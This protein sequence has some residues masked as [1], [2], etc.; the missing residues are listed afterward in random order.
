[1]NDPVAPVDPVVPIG[2]TATAGCAHLVR[3]PYML[4]IG[5]YILLM[6]IASTFLY[7][8]QLQIVDA[9]GGSTDEQTR[10]FATVNLASQGA[11]LVLQ[12]LVTASLLRVAGTGW[13]L[14][15]LPLISIVAFGVLLVSPVFLT[16]VVAQAAFN[17]GRFAFA[18]PARETLFTVLPREDRYKSKAIIDTF[19]Y[20]AG[21]VLGAAGIMGTQKFA[22]LLASRAIGATVASAA[23]LAAPLGLIWILLAFWLGGQRRHRAETMAFESE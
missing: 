2:G 6:T 21:D 14:A 7:F 17:A 5:G 1:S 15:A 4:G 20:R 8:T 11:T 10:L 18:K 16:I 13:T 22:P 19:V 9:M 3:S 12:L 23:A